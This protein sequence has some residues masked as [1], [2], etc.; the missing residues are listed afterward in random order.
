MTI[1]PPPTGWP[2]WLRLICLIGGLAL[3]VWI[4]VRVILP[5]VVA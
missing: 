4:I 5:E 1:E 2:L 3:W